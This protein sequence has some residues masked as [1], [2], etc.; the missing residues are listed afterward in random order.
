MTKLSG[1]K[2]PH[3]IINNLLPLIDLEDKLETN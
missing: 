3:Y 1:E 2:D